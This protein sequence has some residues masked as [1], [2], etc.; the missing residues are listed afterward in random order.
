MGRYQ[1]QR[2]DPETKLFY[3][4]DTL[5]G[6]IN[7]DFSDD[8]SPDNEFRSIVNFNMDTRGSLY[9][10]MGFGKL[11]ALSQIFNLFETLPE[12]KSKSV[13]NPDVEKTN[14]NIVYMKLLKND[15]RVFRNLATYI[16]DKAYR[17]Y[18]KVYGFQNN[19]WELLMI[20]SN[21]ITKLSTAW[22][23]KCTLPEL[24]YGD[25]GEPLEED[26]IKVSSNVFELPVFF[27]H[28]SNLTNIETI[29]FFDKIYFTGNDK[30][31]VC[32]NRTEDKFE[33]SGFD[34]EGNNG[35]Y[36]PTAMDIRKI[37]FNV[38]GDDPLYWVDYQG[39]ST[40][41]IQGI[42][43]TTTDGVPLTII[44]SGG[45]FRLNI[46][47]T[48]ENSDFNVTFKEGEQSLTAT[49]TE[50]QEIQKTGLKVYDV[51]LQT[52]PTTE[53][54]IKIELKDVTLDPYYDYYQ[55]GQVDPEAKPVTS[56]N[57]GEYGICE[58]YNRAVYYKGDTLWF[59]EIN[60]F[61]Y[62]PNY[63]YVSLPIEP[64]DEITKVVFFRNVYI[65]FTKNVIYKMVG[66][67]G[68]SDF[69]T[70]PVNLS[71]GCHAPNTVC[72]IENELYFASKRGLYA[73]KSSDFVDG[74][75]NLKELDTKVKQLTSDRTMFVGDITP[76]AV[77]YN[78][79]SD[80]AYAIRYK[81]KYMLFLNNYLSSDADYEPITNTDVLVYQYELKAF[82]EIRFPI[83]PTFL[84]MVDNHI[85]T[86]GTIPQKEEYTDEE[87]LLSYDFENTQV[88]NGTIADSS[89]NKL[90]AT[91]MGGLISAPGKGVIT[92][93]NGSYVSVP[94]LDVDLSNGFNVNFEGALNAIDNVKLL[95]LKRKDPTG[96]S[97]PQ[98]FSLY[99]NWSNGY[100]GELV[101]NTVPNESTLENTVNY[102]FRLH[103]SDTSITSNRSG[104]F[105]LKDANG[106]YLIGNTSFSF[107]FGS[108]TIIDIKSGAFV[109]KYEADGTYSK[110]WTLTL[111][112]EYPTYQTV[113][114]NGPDTT[115]DVIK[116]PSWGNNLY[117]I[118]LIGRA[119]AY[120][121]GCTITYTPYVHLE[122]SGT[123][124]VGSRAMYVWVNGT[125]HNH[126]IPS[127]SH[128]SGT[129][130]D[131]SGGEQTQNI[132]YTGQP[133]I[134]IDARY[135][136]R[137]T[138]SGTYR[139]NL[140]I[141]AFDFTLPYSNSRN[142]TVWNAYTT[143]GQT[144]IT[145]NKIWKASYRE[146]SITLVDNNKVNIIC[147]SEYSETNI[148]IVNE[149]INLS[150]A[151]NILVDFI[152]NTNDYTVNV[153]VN[154]E[155]FGSATIPST[156]IV[157]GVRNDNK[158]LY[159][160]S[161][162]LNKFVVK[163]GKDNVILDYRFDTG[164]GTVI[165]DYSGKNI[166]GTL[167]G[168]ITWITE[169]GLMFDGTSGYLVLPI[170]DSSVNF[171]NGFVIE[172]ECK[173]DNSNSLSRI[174]DLATGYGITNSDDR[175]SI[176]ANISDNNKTINFETSS[177]S[178][179]SYKLSNSQID[180]T[181]RHKWKFVV[182]DNGKNY[183]VS[184]SCD[185]D[186]LVSTKFN[187]GG[188]SNITRRSN[189][190]GKSNKASDKLFKGMIYNLS[191]KINASNTPV[192]IYEG[193]MYE[194]DTAY[195][196]FGKP[197]EIELETKGMN[198]QYPM[199]IKKLKNVFVK[200]VGGYEYSSFF[201][202][203]YC[204]GHLVN[205]PKNYICY[206]D[207]KTRQVVYEYTVNKDLTFDERA[208]VLGTMRLDNTRLG[209]GT[210]ETKKLIIPA[211]G[212][213]FTVKIYGESD[214]S[215]SIDSIGFVFKLGKV[216]EG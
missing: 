12:V 88:S 16:G 20:T 61:N 41:S 151:Y 10:R 64:T 114:D 196:D 185:N 158:V 8:S 36:K 53:V 52:V 138:I 191:I 117:G 133:T 1:A 94:D 98:T 77:R 4:V 62:V 29:E 135:N 159:N 48:G 60:N 174:I 125:Q 176:N 183:D 188:I 130:V 150:Y 82:S 193:A 85:L 111:S 32:F 31:L 129:V 184:L 45:M 28:N 161:G 208:A 168:D 154:D 173:V 109:V 99:T 47:Y 66:S 198:L 76:S 84:F 163:T 175:C 19:S 35:A 3:I 59:S 104:S 34:Y 95:Q 152:K 79:I 97:T 71:V 195:S 189:Y 132:N 24:K 6:G 187:Y 120:N 78:G 51:T 44:P 102:T 170:I 113:W 165:K 23:F 147:N 65:I 171:T 43:L 122:K 92:S 205:D 145:L 144:T 179:K 38:L 46:L 55:V 186:I 141:D 40:N 90:N 112:G 80:N 197:M 70:V 68:S 139:E 162:V 128:N 42:Y 169:K 14:D 194:Y 201:F 180:L 155:L 203:L 182:S 96:S 50:D 25:N 17:Q 115:F 177:V 123:L 7:T 210:Y 118:R 67:F 5:I 140:D 212:K 126:T 74:I 167:N 103:R 142:E 136:I 214:D 73:L 134:S 108:S 81:D 119:K 21:D 215:L 93:G 18:Q 211:K 72:T 86:Y 87:V 13:D 11:D 166:Q 146:I 39:I 116:R 58:M 89:A 137:A 153:Y 106:N 121:G 37:G 49:V 131:I 156:S 27:R 105:S 57:V 190:I 26:T 100:R 216:K 15:N 75:E 9:K 56:L 127:I 148:D 202:E 157:N 149:D 124:Y 181:Q 178:G 206:V 207:E 54:E 110:T 143:T 160:T 204:D 22:L 101:C 200:G 69:E 63:N 172:F 209:E 213:N 2:G 91:V 30:G 164:N 33:Y 199:H 107:D 192:P 83:K